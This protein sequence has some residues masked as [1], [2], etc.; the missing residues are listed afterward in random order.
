MTWLFVTLIVAAM[1][2]F[3]MEILTPFFGVFVGLGLTALT[4]S[5]F[6]AYQI[7][8]VFG[9]V[10]LV[11]AF[12]WVPLY[13]F[14]V[15]KILPKTPLGKRLFLG[16]FRRHD[17]E[18]GYEDKAERLKAMVGSEGVT[19]TMLRP[20]GAVRIEGK[21]LPASA[22]SGTIRQGVPVKVV[23]ATSME[24]I[25]RPADAEAPLP[26]EASPPQANPDP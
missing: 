14:A 13:L 7:H 23:R 16:K 8:Q 6:V 22:E 11:F 1:V 17:E 15:V 26:P 10:A 21:R 4:A 18:P 9:L 20:A 3:A 2:L 5:V 12:V 19:A 25:V 24:L